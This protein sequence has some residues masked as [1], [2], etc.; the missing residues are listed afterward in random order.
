MATWYH[1]AISAHAVA[2][3][4]RERQRFSCR[5]DYPHTA[6]RKNHVRLLLASAL[7]LV[8]VT[9]PSR[10]MA[11]A[12]SPAPNCK[13][14][15]FTSEKFIELFYTIAMHG[16]LTDIPFLENVLQVNFTHQFAVENGKPNPHWIVYGGVIPQAPFSVGLEV[17][18]DRD[19]QLRWGWI[20]EMTF[21][22]SND[23]TIHD[24]LG[25]ASSELAGKFEGRP[26]TSP[27]TDGAPFMSGT[28]QLHD[29]GKF[30]TTIR[31]NYTYGMHDGVIDGASIRQ[32]P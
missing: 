18:T 11:T 1:G 10:V 27:L 25:I 4:W 20:A 7:F 28:E 23:Q 24:C 9:Q 13:Q 6:K 30:G 2:R 17:R 29:V 14:S 21:G 22:D 31:I 12:T 15:T 16:D 19:E 3:C 26:I 5:D 8:V 32:S